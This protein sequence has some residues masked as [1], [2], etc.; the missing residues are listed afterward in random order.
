MILR[1]HLLRDL[2]P[3]ARGLQ[4]IGLVHHG[5]MLAAA[6]GILESEFKDALDLEAVVDV[7]IV[8][9]V[10]AVQTALLAEIHASGELADA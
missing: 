2:A 6:H 1:L 7:G 9:G 5:Q 10:T 3:E 4:D 8:C